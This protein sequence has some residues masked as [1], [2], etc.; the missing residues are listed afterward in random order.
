MELITDIDLNGESNLDLLKKMYNKFKNTNEE[1]IK[2]HVVSK[3]LEILGYDATDFYYEHSMYHKDGRADIAVKIDQMTYLYVEV[4]ASD[5]KLDEK[6][7]HQLAQY[8]HSSGLT[9]GILTNGKRFILFNDSIITPANPNRPLVLDKIVFDIDLF[10]AKD[11]ELIK[12][13]TKESIFETQITNY[14]REI[15]K[16]KALKHPDGIGNWNVYKST[17]YNFFKYYVNQQGRFRNLEDIRLDEFEAFLV[18]EINKKDNKNGKTVNSAKTLYNKYSHIR[19]FFQTLKVRNSG[20][21]EEKNKLISRLQANVVE[22]NSDVSKVLTEENI[23]TIL[24]FYDTRQYALRNKTIFLLCLCFG[25]ERSTIISLTYNSIKNDKLI[26]DDRELLLSPKL[27]ELVKDLINENKNK[28]IK[29][30]S[31]FYSLYQKKYRPISESTANYTF[32]ILAEIN[33]EWCILSP[34]NIRAYLIKELFNSNYSLE[35]IVYITGADLMSINK[36]ITFNEIII[37]VKSKG[38]KN[39]VHPFYIFLY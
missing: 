24:D 35:E 3:F 34:K 30:D 7:Q 27:L 8:L 12:Y 4:K 32:D 13:F 6:E 31:L 23:Q 14:F 9:W 36:L 17:L 29:G 21:E 26:I 22:R 15:A 20:F 10:N 39:K 25:L 11:K 5:K 28:K 19:A 38:K 18:Y 2:I 1:N 37:K 33:Q 16:Y